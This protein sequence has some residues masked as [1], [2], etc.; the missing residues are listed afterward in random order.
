MT[1]LQL[2]PSA[3][4]PCTRTTLCASAVLAPRAR[5]CP[6]TNV[7]ESTATVTPTIALLAIAVLNVRRTSIR[8]SPTDARSHAD[9]RC[10]RS[11]RRRTRSCRRE[12][13]RIA[14]PPLPEP[15]HPPT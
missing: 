6:E 9:D 5:L 4:A 15:D 10:C 11:A 14:A 13:S 7:P 1:S 12:G 3:H 8:P 2:E